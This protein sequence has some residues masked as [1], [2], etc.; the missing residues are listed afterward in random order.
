MLA[1]GGHICNFVPFTDHC[2]FASAR[3]E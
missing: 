2:M 1:G 3:P